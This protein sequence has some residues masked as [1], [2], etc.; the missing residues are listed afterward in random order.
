MKKYLGIMF[1]ASIALL[2]V[3]VYNVNADGYADG[4]KIIDTSGNWTG[5]V[6]D[7]PVADLVTK[8]DSD[9]VNLQG[10][11]SGATAI[12]LDTASSTNLT[13]EDCRG[14]I[15]INNDN[16]VVNYE[17]PAAQA[18]LV[19]TFANVLYAQVITVDAGSGDIIVLND[20]TALSAANSADS[21]GAIDDVGTFVAID[22]TY[23]KIIGEQ[24]AWVD[25]GP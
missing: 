3:Y 4:K 20:G 17:L 10:E 7:N 9:D 21:S 11:I 16:D 1:L 6:D 25:G 12:T 22:G 19:V 14:K 2:S 5:T 8:T 24:N 18:G 15:R 23:W 13:V